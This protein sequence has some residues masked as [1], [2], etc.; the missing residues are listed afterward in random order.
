MGIRILVIEDDLEIADF[1]VRGL[2]EEGFNVVLASDGDEG[3]HRLRGET[4]D[5]VLLDWWL[6]TV[7]GLTLL[8]EF[9]QK[10]ANTPV[11]LLTGATRY[12]TVSAA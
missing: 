9:R 6:P 4:W 7:D 8:G 1:L 3:R 5:V 2:R 11:L 10:D 12:P